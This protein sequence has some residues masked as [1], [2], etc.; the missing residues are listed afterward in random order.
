MFGTIPMGMG[1]VKGNPTLQ[2]ST[3]ANCIAPVS[4]CVSS[5]T[6]GSGGTYSF[7]NLSPGNYYLLVTYYNQVLY[8]TAAFTLTSGQNLNNFNVGLPYLNPPSQNLAVQSWVNSSNSGDTDTFTATVTTLEG[9]GNPIDFAPGDPTWTPTGTVY[10][11]DQNQNLLA[12]VALDSVSGNTA[13]ATFSTSTLAVGTD[14]IEAVFYPTGSSNPQSEESNPVTVN[15]LPD[16]T[17]TTLSSSLDPAA[18]GALVSITATPTGT[19]TFYNYG[20][21]LGT[22]TLNSSGTATFTTSTLSGGIYSLTAFYGGDANYSD[23]TSFL[24]LTLTITASTTTTISSSV[25]PAAAGALFNL[26]ALVA[27]SGGIPTGTVTFFDGNSQLGTANLDGT[28]TA[29][30]PIGTLAVG[31]QTLTAVYNSDGA[32]QTSTSTSLTE[33]INTGLSSTTSLTSSANPSVDGNL[34]TFTA[35]VTGSGATPTG[36]V[37]FYNG[38]T[39][40]D[41]VA[42]GTTATACFSTS[43]LPVGTTNL[44]AV[45][46]GDSNYA[47]SQSVQVSQVVNP[48]VPALSSATVNGANVT[49]A[50]Q[51]VSL[52]GTQRSM[53]D[54]I[55]FQFNEPVTLDPGAFTIALHAGVSV[56][57]GTPGTV[58]TLPTLSWTSPDGGLIWVV[59]FSGAGVVGGSIADGDYDI[60]V[61]STA[62]HGDG[63]TMTSNVT[64]TFFRLYGDTNGDGQVSGRPDEVAMQNALGTSI[65]QAGYLAY[66]DYN[67]DGVIAGRPEFQQFEIAPGY[68]LHGFVSDDLMSR[69]EAPFLPREGTSGPGAVAL[70]LVSV[71]PACAPAQCSAK[72]ARSGLPRRCG[73]C[74]WTIH[75]HPWRTTPQS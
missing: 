14:T 12:T 58:G 56:D 26:T 19:V 8:Q 62:V 13:T 4:S 17:T 45:Y 55:V 71:I 49:I 18:T 66:L 57:G 51:S 30:F 7:A 50:G 5:L 65:G 44:T 52:A 64:N 23:S 73:D 2:A 54:D 60:T 16:S 9:N 41:T 68:H 28:G 34:V 35:T 69:P 70:E 67:G 47:S 39:L 63:R 40:L 46:M 42:L 36:D 10:F 21:P 1:R 20:V 29:V 11:Y 33:V 43:V 27:S 74:E 37:A 6:A 53:V 72:S 25:N 3:S 75:Q 15:A 38:G 32:F 61:V 22:G 59:T 48:L 31:N 24:P